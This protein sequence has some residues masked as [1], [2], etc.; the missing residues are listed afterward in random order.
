MTDASKLRF[1]VHNGVLCAY[2]DGEAAPFARSAAPVAAPPNFTMPDSAS[3]PWYFARVL[4]PEILATHCIGETWFRSAE[5]M[6]RSRLDDWNA[7][8]D[9]VPWDGGRLVAALCPPPGTP[10]RVSPSPPPTLVAPVPKRARGRSSILPPAA[11]AD[12][13]VYDA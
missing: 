2:K 7:V 13:P 10:P 3:Q 6:F 4:F 11:A 12:T 9:M 8:F 1:T 5:P